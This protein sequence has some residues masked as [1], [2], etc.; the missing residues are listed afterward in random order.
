MQSHSIDTRWMKFHS[1]R[2]ILVFPIF[3][4]ASLFLFVTLRLC[5]SALKSTAVFRLSLNIYVLR[6][7]AESW[8]KLLKNSTDSLLQLK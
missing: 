3:Y 1:V 5:A 6:S 4:I 2:K 8:V 7:N